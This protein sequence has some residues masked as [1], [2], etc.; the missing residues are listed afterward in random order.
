[1]Y[2]VVCGSFIQA[3]QAVCCIVYKCFMCPV[4]VSVLLSHTVLLELYQEKLVTEDELRRIKTGVNL[5][6]RLVF[7][8]STKHQ[9]VVIRS[10]HVLDNFGHNEGA[11]QLRGWCRYSTGTSV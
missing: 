10:V 7:V 3:A 5:C 4:C 1:M 2:V 8:Q 9:E 11:K 6:E